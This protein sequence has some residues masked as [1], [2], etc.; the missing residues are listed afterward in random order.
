MLVI[1][2][3]KRKK[4]S[5]LLLNKMKKEYVSPAMQVKMLTVCTMI[6][7]SIRGTSGADGLGVGGNSD[8]AGITEGAAKDRY[9]DEEAEA[10]FNT[11]TN[12][13]DGGLW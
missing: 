4:I 5:H 6:A 12:G 1:L 13:W 2:Q 11:N 3:P 7:V 10:F 8:E 9:D